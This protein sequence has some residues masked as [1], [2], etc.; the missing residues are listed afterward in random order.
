M[1]LHLVFVQVND[2]SCLSNLQCVIN[3]DAQGYDQVLFT[4]YTLFLHNNVPLRTLERSYVIA[5]VSS[6]L[7]SAFVTRF[8]TF[9]SHT[10][11]CFRWNLDS[12]PLVHQC[13]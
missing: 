5:S 11:G 8:L 10:S 12:L 3:S 13:G 1:F 6:L 2:G 4:R 9:P 7:C